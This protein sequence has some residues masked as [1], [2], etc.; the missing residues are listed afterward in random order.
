M[1]RNRRQ[2]SRQGGLN[3]GRHSGCQ[4]LE[5]HASL[6]V[7]GEAAEFR[8][9]TD[10]D[11]EQRPDQTSHRTMI[12]ESRVIITFLNENGERKSTEGGVNLAERGISKEE[13]AKLRAAFSTFAEDWERPEMDAYDQL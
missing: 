8:R 4:I 12:K 1:S 5:H 3:R 6:L 7:G 13:A 2:D 10:H 9:E 11:P